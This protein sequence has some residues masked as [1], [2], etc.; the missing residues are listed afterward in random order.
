ML[1]CEVRCWVYQG[2]LGC[3]INRRYNNITAVV[4]RCGY[5]PEIINCARWSSR[6]RK[7]ATITVETNFNPNLNQTQ[8]SKTQTSK[9][10]PFLDLR[11]ISDLC[12]VPDLHP[13]S[14]HQHFVF[15]LKFY[16]S[17]SKR[18]W[19]IHQPTSSLVCST[20]GIASKEE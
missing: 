12:L 11:S 20:R 13:I 14:P 7:K 1:H 2:R 17:V 6:L 9:T 8:P 16:A 19:T 18:A 15:N 4:L 5:C 10:P 3:G